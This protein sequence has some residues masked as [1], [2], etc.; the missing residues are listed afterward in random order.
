MCKYYG[1]TYC[2]TPINLIDGTTMI[3]HGCCIPGSCKGQDAIKVLENNIFCFQSFKT[4]WFNQSLYP[5]LLDQIEI[6]TVCQEIPRTYNVFFFIVIIIFFIFFILAM[7]ASFMYPHSNDEEY[8]YNTFVNI[9]SLQTNIN[10]LTSKR[11]NKNLLFIDGIRV[12]SIIWLIFAHSFQAYFL[13]GTTDLSASVPP[14]SYI[15]D[16]VFFKNSRLKWNGYITHK[17]ISVFLNDFMVDTFFCLSGFFGVFS[18][19]KILSNTKISPSLNDNNDTK[20]KCKE[21]CKFSLLSY[22]QRYLRLAPMIIYV[23]L[24]TMS[25]LDQIPNGS[26]VT[27]RNLFYDCCSKTFFDKIFFTGNWSYLFVD[28]GCSLGCMA[29]LWFI[30]VDYQLFLLLPLCAYLLCKKGPKFAIKLTAFLIILGIIFRAILGGS[31]GFVANTN[32][33]GIDS[34]YSYF[35]LVL[36]YDKPWTRMSAYFCGALLSMIFIKI[37][38][39]NKNYKLSF[40]RYFMLQSF[41]CVLFVCLVFV[42]FD[43]LYNQPQN[44][45]NLTQNV[46]Y[47]IFC[48]PVWGITL[49]LFIFAL[50]YRDRN[51]YSSFVF[52]ILSGICYTVLSRLSFEIYLIHYFWFR[53]WNMI[54]EKPV[55]YNLFTILSLASFCLILSTLTAL[56]LWIFMEKPIGNII[57]L[58]TKKYCLKQ[59]EKRDNMRHLVSDKDD[60]PPYDNNATL[61]LHGGDAET[62]VH[63]L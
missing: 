47:Y 18:L 27:S 62:D 12:W 44:H 20:C 25:L 48:K 22:L 15:D 58:I 40:K 42:P 17:F 10:Y 61:Y 21:C 4:A 54:I 9:F 16:F 37:D 19:Y 63:S 26:H 32:F 28:S 31:F 13:S 52:N 49:C 53:I 41:V 14:I 36:S 3:Q 6:A 39:D 56:I 33:P 11:K 55:Y 1:N 45:W 8:T 23:T 59:K 30:Y 38:K 7:V 46:M 35:E 50:R 24:I 57:S 5:D 2:Y 51:H 34:K 43:N 60:T 29:H